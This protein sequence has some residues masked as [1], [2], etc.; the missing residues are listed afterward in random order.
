MV[1][2]EVWLL[3]AAVAAAKPG[4]DGNGSPPVEL[5]EFIGDWTAEEQK[6]IDQAVRPK[7]KSVR[8]RSQKKD[9]GNESA[10]TRNGP[11]R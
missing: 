7:K 9:V 3:A 11:P 6:L 2:L 8:P 10:T 1:G 5:L 4:Q